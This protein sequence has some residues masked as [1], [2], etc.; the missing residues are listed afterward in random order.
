VGAT[1]RKRRVAS[2]SFAVQRSTEPTGVGRLQR[3]AGCRWMRA[4]SACR[5]AAAGAVGCRRRWP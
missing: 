5:G 1:D 2:R 3:P 4:G